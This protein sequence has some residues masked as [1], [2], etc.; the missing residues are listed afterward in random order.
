MH[1][2]AP[3]GANW[4]YPVYLCGILFLFVAEHLQVFVIKLGWLSACTESRLLSLEIERTG[5]LN[6]HFLD[7][8]QLCVNL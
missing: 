4:N 1:R 3:T 7:H 5:H 8:A 6:A 2:T